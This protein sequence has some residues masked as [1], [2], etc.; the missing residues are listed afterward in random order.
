MESNESPKTAIEPLFLIYTKRSEGE[1]Y[2]SFT[3]SHEAKRCA[4]ELAAKSG[5]EVFI[6]EAIASCKVTISPP[7]WQGRYIAEDEIPF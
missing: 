4:E 6:F 7:A 5:Q 3:T 2:R 1:G